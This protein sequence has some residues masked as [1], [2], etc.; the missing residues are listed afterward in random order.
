MMHHVTKVMCLFIV[1]LKNN[2]K[3]KEKDKSNQR[4]QIK[5]KENQNKIYEVKGL[6]KNFH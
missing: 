4:K 1:Q 3:I 2:N 5:R 6:N